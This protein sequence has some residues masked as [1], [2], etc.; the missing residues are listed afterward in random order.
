V[1]GDFTLKI[2]AF[3]IVVQVLGNLA[4]EWLKH[5]GTRRFFLRAFVTYRQTEPWARFLNDFAVIVFTIFTAL[6]RAPERKSLT[7]EAAG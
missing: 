6:V 2:L 1:S 7:I 4:T 3:W 5:P